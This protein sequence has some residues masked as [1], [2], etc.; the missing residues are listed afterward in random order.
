MYYE[1]KK[2]FYIKQ[3]GPAIAVIMIS[4]AM[5]VTGLIIGFGPDRIAKAPV[6]NNSYTYSKD[7][8]TGTVKAVNGLEIVVV[9]DGEE[10]L[11]NMIGIEENKKNIN[12]SKTIEKDLIGKTVV[13]DFD[14]VKSE[15]GKTYGYIYLNNTFYNETLLA[16]GLAELRAERNNINK[17]D[18][19]VSAQ[20]NARHE[21]LGIWSY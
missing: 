7:A 3:Y 5:I 18:I 4:V 20:I 8:I 11:V 1:D 17:L 21:G 9:A 14:T 15:N 12:L 2:T 13:V 6:E 10:Y 16:R 19:L